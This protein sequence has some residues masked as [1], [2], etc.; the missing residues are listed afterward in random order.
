[1]RRALAASR[2]DLLVLR[3]ANELIT[4]NPCV[5]VDSASRARYPCRRLGNRS[6][7]Q[8]FLERC[9]RHRLGPLF[10]L[11][12]LTGLRRGEITGLYWADVDLAAGTITVRHNRVSVAGRVQEQTTKT[13]SAAAALCR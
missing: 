11:A 6:T 10:E 7:S 5:H 1:M 8:T 4:V 2:D 3:C 13:R 9:G 12:V